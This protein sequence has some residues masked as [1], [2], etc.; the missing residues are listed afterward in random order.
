VKVGEP[1]DADAAHRGE[2]PCHDA[3]SLG[4]L[5]SALGELDAIER[6]GR[7]VELALAIQQVAR[8]HLDLGMPEAAEWYYQ[9]AL[10]WART[11]GSPATAIEILC[12]LADTAV[13]LAR[14]HGDEAR[15]YALLERARDHA[16]EAATLSSRTADRH[17]EASTL[18]LVSQVL[19]R[20][21]DH[22]D[23]RALRERAATL[24]E[25]AVE[26]TPAAG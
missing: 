4:R 1:L 21:G 13:V 7:P 16:Y 15:R 20:C 9:R 17:C 18:Y 23:A 14:D 19:G 11:L 25:D 10:A 24:V 22:G 6:R 12:E 5:A 26:I 3:Q 8:C 2:S